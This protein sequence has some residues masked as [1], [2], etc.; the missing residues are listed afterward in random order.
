[1]TTLRFKPLLLAVALAL[2]GSAGIAN[3]GGDTSHRYC[4]PGASMYWGIFGY[5][6]EDGTYAG[7][8]PFECKSGAGQATRTWNDDS[9]TPDQLCAQQSSIEPKP[10]YVPFQ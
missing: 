2:I 3:A 6:C 7:V 1:M 5:W 9:R 10:V 8:Q 4:P